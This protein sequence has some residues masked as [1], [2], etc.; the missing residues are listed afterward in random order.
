MAAALARCSRLLRHQ[1]QQQLRLFA[2]PTCQQH[3][4][5]TLLSG[6]H[7]RGSTKVGVPPTPLLF[8]RSLS[9]TSTHNDGSLRFTSSKSQRRRNDDNNDGEGG[10]EAKVDRDT[11][12]IT[13]QNSHA[14]YK[15][16]STWEIVRALLVFQMCSIPALVDNNMKLMKLGEK[17]LGKTL[18]KMVM[19]CTVYGHFVAGENEKSIRPVINRMSQF[20]VKAIL[21]YS[22]EED[23]SP[24]QAAKVEMESCVSAAQDAKPHDD[25]KQ[26]QP[27]R[28]FADRRQKV[29]SAR[30]YFYMNEAQCERNM[31]IFL[32]SIDAVS[33][34]TNRTGF[35]A[36]KM[37]ALGRPQLLMQLSETIARTRKYFEEVTGLHGN[38]ILQN[39]D[40][41]LFVKRFHE[42]HISTDIPEV[43][44]WLSQMT[45]DQK[46]LIHLFSWS[47]L[48]DSNILMSDLFKV[49]NLQSKKVERIISALTEEEEEM[50][51]NMM[52]RLH[53]IAKRAQEKD[54]RV[55]IDAEQ[56]YFQPA[57][58]RIA[59]ELMRK[60]NKEK[61]FIFNTYQCYLKEAYNNVILDI[62]QAKRQNFY[63]GAKLVRGAY[64]EQE[65]ERAITLEYED[66]INPTYESTNA[67]YEKTVLECLRRIKEQNNRTI[68]IMM[69][70]HN[71][72]T[73]RYTVTKMKELGIGPQ[74]RVVC[75]GQLFG[76]CDQVSFPLGQAGYSV[77]KYVPYG[78]V[79][80]V[81]PYL[82]RR[83]QE[84][85]SIMKTEKEK[86][87]LM[88]ELK[89]RLFTGQ[90]VYTPRGNYTT[91]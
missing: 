59:M 19:K 47:G 82:A 60:Y 1:Q 28:K 51:K 63:F 53:T 55:M 23:I 81:L 30:T 24:E 15:S 80:E 71:E 88:E 43:Q 70:T 76:M 4:F 46:G 13:F 52:R 56:T 17:V 66:P 69:A 87:L 73:I 27:S 32:H 41:E 84:N 44:K 91:V 38:V 85:K 79:L 48:I 67:M 21:D 40:P 16:K 61:A 25:M 86:R 75:F 5:N 39:V 54:V 49:P 18:F 65:R 90:L 58:S 72:D 68:A 8:V 33:G 12:D 22:V 26:Y 7:P 10:E 45:Y 77:Y 89:R 35:T 74:D 83:A 6:S 64:M 78:P 3:A 42:K 36:I 62:E 11:L 57:I 34:V 9:R 20:G 37:T 50:F 14:A 29:T 2:P 31:D